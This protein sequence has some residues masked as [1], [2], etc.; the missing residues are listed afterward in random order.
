MMK[1]ITSIVLL[2]VLNGYDHDG[3]YKYVWQFVIVYLNWV[4]MTLLSH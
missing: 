3:P 2:A 1:I 4:H